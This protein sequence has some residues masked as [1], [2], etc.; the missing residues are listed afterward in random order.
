MKEDEAVFPKLA[1]GGKKRSNGGGEEVKACILHMYAYEQH[2]PIQT[3]KVM[4]IFM[5]K[6]EFRHII[7]GKKCV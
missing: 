5:M 3:D 4:N 1:F 2:I 7:F 6:C